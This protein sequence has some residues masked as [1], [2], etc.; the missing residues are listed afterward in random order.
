[1]VYV[2]FGGSST[3]YIV[4]LTTILCSVYLDTAIFD[5]IVFS[6]I[7]FQFFFMMDG[8]QLSTK[9][10]KLRLRIFK[11]LSKEIKMR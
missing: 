5:E 8:I 11:Q 3:V 1:M 7:T 2:F 9:F 10:I 6:K 4:Q